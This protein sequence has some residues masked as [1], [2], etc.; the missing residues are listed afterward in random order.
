M[1]LLIKEIENRTQRGLS[2]LNKLPHVIPH[3]KV[4][5]IGILCGINI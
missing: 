2:I 4:C 1:S 5:C 3:R